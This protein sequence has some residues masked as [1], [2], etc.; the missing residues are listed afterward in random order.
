MTLAWLLWV[1]EAERHP[2]AL[3]WPRQVHTHPGLLLFSLE[4]CI[5]LLGARVL[6]CPAFMASLSTCRRIGSLGTR[7]GST[8]LD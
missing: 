6:P 5:D 1:P 2:G 7:A 8:V 3:E 4:L